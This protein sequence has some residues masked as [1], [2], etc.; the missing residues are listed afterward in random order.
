MTY[1]VEHKYAGDSVEPDVT[2]QGPAHAV[3]QYATTGTFAIRSPGKLLASATAEYEILK[4]P[5]AHVFPLPLTVEIQTPDGEPFTA[6]AVTVADLEKFRDLH[7]ASQGLWSY[8]IHGQQQVSLVDPGTEVNGI[9]GRWSI[10]VEETVTSQSAPP[11][12]NDR[13]SA[14][15]EHTYTFDLYR[16]GTFVATAESDGLL[17]V[18][19]PMR[20]LDPGGTEVAN[21]DTGELTFPV[22]LETLDSSRDAQGTV[23]PWSLEVLPA[24]FSPDA[25][26]TTV[27]AT[28]LASRRI[29][30]QTLQSRIDDLIGVD[31]SKISVFGDMRQEEETLLARLEILDEISA[32]TIDVL[33]LLKSRLKPELQD[34]GVDVN[35]IKA[36]VP[37]VL[38]SHSRN[39]PAE[40][41][42]SLDDLKLDKINITIGASERI[43]PP[44]PAVKLRLIVN[45]G[46]TVKLGGFPIATVGITDTDAG[47]N[48]IEAEVGLRLQTDG[49]FA[50]ES[51]LISDPFDIDVSW[52]AAVAAGVVSA[53]LLVQG[54]EGIADFVNLG[55][56]LLVE[57]GFHHFLAGVGGQVPPVIAMILGDDFTYRSLR[58]DGE[59][60]V[61]DY[62]APV[63]PDPKPTPH[64][65][66]VIGRSITQEGP[67]IWE[68]RPPL[69]GDT[70]SAQN[71]NQKID[72]IVVVM[73]ENRSFDHVL[74]Y[75]AQ[76]PGHEDSDGLTTDLIGVLESLPP[77]AFQDD[78]GIDKL[79]QYALRRLGTESG[80]KPNAF[81]FKTKFPASVAHS[82]DD[83]QM[84][85]SAQI[86]L[87]SGRQ[88]SSPQGFVQD[89]RERVPKDSSEIYMMDVL[90]YYEAKDLPFFAFLAENYAYCERYFCSHPGPTIPNR[91]YSLAGDLQHDRNGEALINNGGENFALSRA[92]NIFD[93]LTRKRVSWRVYESFPSVTML[94]MFAR[95]ATDNT[96]IAPL[97]RLGSD[98]ALGNLPAVTVIDPRMHSAPRS[99]DHSPKADMF[100]GQLFLQDVYETLRSNAAVWE[101]T[102][103]IITYDEHGGFYDHVPPPVADLRRT[104][105]GG[106]TDG[107]FSAPAVSSASD[108][109]TGYGLRVPTFVVSPWTSAG[110]GPDIVLDHCSI[111]KTILARFCGDTRPFL[112]D[113]VDASLTFDAYLSA[114]APRL[115][116]PPP[117]P[118]AALPVVTSATGI[119]TGPVSREQLNRD[120][121]EF[122]DLSGLFARILLGRDPSDGPLQVSSPPDQSTMLGAPVDLQLAFTGGTGPVTWAYAGLPSGLT[123]DPSGHITG[124]PA[125]SG[126]ASHLVTVTATD[127]NHATAT[128][129]FSWTTLT[130]VP[131]VMGMSRTDAITELRNAQLTI[132][133][134]SK[135]N[136]CIDLAGN[137]LVQSLRAGSIVPESAEV[138]LTVSSGMD[139]DGHKC[140]E[141]Q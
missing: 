63:E 89:F 133:P 96:S 102:L 108:L 41:H 95:Y 84:Q 136:R 38:Y 64:Y 5:S 112:S 121:V 94:R 128:A 139:K 80:I 22:S 16:V 129:S 49:T 111:L 37:Y 106:N 20:L 68:V 10:A 104:Q 24:P 134:E 85:L 81:G 115:D 67:G 23:R 66:G 44:L 26:D 60:I 65:L 32:G 36:N 83:V 92:L 35:E 87:P 25:A 52:E 18:Q 78:D 50:V 74:G 135:D 141:L 56:N 42:V 71:L 1:T 2:F 27:S 6:D 110:K 54:A 123:G 29:H 76:L 51:W 120:D 75:R 3:V 126:T 114:P 13:L 47:D 140:P 137:V 14:E 91:M 4:E 98:V 34:P 90:G 40:M 125:P 77:F 124:A 7:G 116:V 132:G 58:V 122:D 17:G 45:G 131:A 62:V 100:D 93:V 73:M 46:A 107:G 53:G 117:S 43:Q 101:S 57:A 9:T 11:L 127:A 86:S 118:L 69:L 15:D 105:V 138:R 31:G 33:E 109:L 82:T 79:V 21:S 119:D 61:L 103:L 70:W 59:D 99:D 88:I 97:S 113:R 130:Q 8:S 28:V 55:F 72:H 12:V 30:T 48:L 19:R 39:L